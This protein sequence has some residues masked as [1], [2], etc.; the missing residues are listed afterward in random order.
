[1]ATHGAVIRWCRQVR[2]RVHHTAAEGDQELFEQLVEY[3][4]PDSDF[5]REWP[6]YQLL[7]NLIPAYSRTVSAIYDRKHPYEVTQ[8]PS[9]PE[10]PPPEPNDGLV[11]LRFTAP[12]DDP[13]IPDNCSRHGWIIAREGTRNYLVQF[14]GRYQDITRVVPLGSMRD[15][16]FRYPSQTLRDETP[17]I[18]SR[19]PGPER[20]M[21]TTHG[22][23]IDAL[24][25]AGVGMTVE[26]PSPQG[27]VVVEMPGTDA[28]IDYMAQPESYAARY[29]GFV[30][31]DGWT[32]FEAHDEWQDTDGLPLCGATT[33]MGQLCSNS[34]ATR[35]L[36]AAAWRRLHRHGRCHVHREKQG[37]YFRV[38][39]DDD[40]TS[41]VPFR[42]QRR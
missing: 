10:P 28:M 4:G 16:H 25:H 24:F 29:F 32:D 22:L 1:M 3:L 23:A 9:R 26:L 33:R 35:S 13:K 40:D 36:P 8:P 14:D 37:R 2:H 11:G 31:D 42:R 41:I 19:L 7:A 34:L 39:L 17:E 12:R 15:W 38:H 6:P 30:R 20:E 5:Y 21:T 27:P 18:P